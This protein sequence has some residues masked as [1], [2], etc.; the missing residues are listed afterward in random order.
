[1]NSR[2]IIVILLIAGALAT[3][4]GAIYVLYRNRIAIHYWFSSALVTYG[5]T[6]VFFLLSNL[7][8]KEESR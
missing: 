5:V 1:M 2:K 6:L 7:N 4:I 3:I 8:R